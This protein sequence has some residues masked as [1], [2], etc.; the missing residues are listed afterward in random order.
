MIRKPLLED[1]SRIA[2][3]HIYGWRY[4]Y[5]KIL[6]ETF[7][8]KNRQVI[9]AFEMHKKVI[10]ENTETIDIY[11]DGIIKGFVI[12][13]KSRDKDL[14]DSYELCALYVEPEFIRKGIGNK[15]LK[16]VEQLCREK[17]ISH[18]TI[19]VLEKNYSGRKFYEKNG[20]QPD[21]TTKIIDS[22]NVREL[23]YSKIVSCN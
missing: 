20:Y 2:E 11:D 17:N 6:S 18:I 22:L 13:S 12:H 8:Y 9:K 10:S 7:L 15:L 3:I 16:H 21:G 14:P 1:A 19:W 4:A 23:R 5:K